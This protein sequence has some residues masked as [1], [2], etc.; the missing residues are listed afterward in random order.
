MAPVTS[1]LHKQVLVAT[2]YIPVSVDFRMVCLATSVP[3]RSM[4]S[5][6]F[7]ICLVFFFFPIVW[8]GVMYLQPTFMLE[9]KLEVPSALM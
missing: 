1:A 7:S 3:D 9:L 5:N 6:L 4:K 8:I 2:L